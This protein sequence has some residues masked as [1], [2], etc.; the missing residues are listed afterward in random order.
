[1]EKG[2]WKA[3]AYRVAKSQTQL[4]EYHTHAFNT[5]QISCIDFKHLIKYMHAICVF[6]SPNTAILFHKTT[7]M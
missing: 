1:M 5:S 6:F 7:L 4:S 3:T 2:A